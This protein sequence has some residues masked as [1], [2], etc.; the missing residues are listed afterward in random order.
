VGR[1]TVA[2]SVTAS[3]P[4]D[5]VAALHPVS[6]TTPTIIPAA[7]TSGSVRKRGRSE[8]A[9]IDAEDERQCGSAND[10]FMRPLK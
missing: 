8:Q 5:Q 2:D 7:A 3:G 4:T 10:G 6:A 1:A 9:S